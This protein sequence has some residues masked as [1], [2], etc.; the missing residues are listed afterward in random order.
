MAQSGSQWNTKHLSGGVTAGSVE[1]GAA[2][3]ATNRSCFVVSLSSREAEWKSVGRGDRIM[4]LLSPCCLLSILFINEDCKRGAFKISQRESL[5]SFKV[6]GWRQFI[7][8]PADNN[9]LASLPCINS[10]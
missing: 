4:N 5:E 2:L 8:L 6:K 9:S 10:D 1:A 3:G 7:F